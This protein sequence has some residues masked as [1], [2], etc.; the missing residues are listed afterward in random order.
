MRHGSHESL[1]SQSASG[2]NSP[3]AAVIAFA[4]YPSLSIDILLHTPSAMKT[5]TPV[6]SWSENFPPA[7][8]WTSKDIPDLGGKVFV[9]TGGYGGIG[10][11][12][13]VRS[14]DGEDKGHSSMGRHVESTFGTRR[15][16][17]HPRTIPI[18]I[19]LLCHPSVIHPIQPTPL[20][21]M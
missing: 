7:P 13:T 8:T 5:V 2:S 9:V 16:G 4:F 12:T 14:C 11:E 18:Q 1:G 10:Y 17:L 15:K 19:R 3:A 20:H 6:S 21:P